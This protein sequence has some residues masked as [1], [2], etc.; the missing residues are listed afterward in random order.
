MDERTIAVEIRSMDPDGNV[1]M[2]ASMFFAIRGLSLADA[3]NA[4]INGLESR[5]GE[6]GAVVIRLPDE[7]ARAAAMA[8][9]ALDQRGR[10]AKVRLDEFRARSAR[11]EGRTP[12]AILNNQVIVNIARALPRNEQ[13]LLD[14]QGVG[15]LK[16]MKYGEGILAITRSLQPTPEDRYDVDR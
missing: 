4:L 8:V 1:E 3:R 6:S 15:P 2:T 7:L 11:Q 5:N 9:G 14:V 10:E 16:V 12:A 13:E